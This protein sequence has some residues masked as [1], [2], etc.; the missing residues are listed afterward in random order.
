MK[1]L[2]LIL[3]VALFG[4][5]AQSAYAQNEGVE[6]WPVQNVPEAQCAYTE[7]E[8]V[9]VTDVWVE[10]P[11]AV[12]ETSFMQQYGFWILILGVFIGIPL[13]L[14]IVIIAIVKAA[15][16]PDELAMLKEENERLQRK[17]EI[18]RLKEENERLRNNLK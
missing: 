4:F 1:R 12:Q 13:V 8:C 18:A 15:K 5:A 3:V 10:E 2:I 16:R 17:A 7:D 6:D 11:A 9:A 14:T